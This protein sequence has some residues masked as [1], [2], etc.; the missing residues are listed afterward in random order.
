LFPKLARLRVPALLIHGQ[1][2][3]VPVE[4]ARRIAEAIPGAR[5]VL[6]GG[7]GH[8]SYLEAPDAVRKTV[9]EFLA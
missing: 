7:S 9:V 8:F 2:D 1:H 4:C 3:L 6:L 5:F